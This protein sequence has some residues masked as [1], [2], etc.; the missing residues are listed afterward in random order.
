MKRNSYKYLFKNI[1][2]LTISNFSSKILTF[3]LVLL[4]TRALSTAEFGIFDVMST[5]VALLFPIITIDIHESVL[6]FSLDSTYEKQKQVFSYGAQT[7]FKSI[8]L[9]ISVVI[10]NHY[11]R[12]VS[13]IDEYAAYFILLYVASVLNHLMYNFS[14]G[15]E[16]VKDFAIASLISSVTGLLL[17]IILLVYVKAGLEGYFIAHISSLMIPVL[18]LSMRIKIWKF[19]SINRVDKTLCKEMRGFSIPLIMNQIGWW[20]NNSSD[21]YVVTMLSGI[22]ANGVY[23]LAYKIPSILNVFQL[24]FSQAW[25]LSATKDY[26]SEDKSGFFSNIYNTYNFLMVLIC[27]IIIIGS[28]IIAKIMYGPAFYNAYIYAPFLTIAVVFGALSG[29][30]GGVFS[31]VKDSKIFGQSTIIGALINLVLNFILVFLMGPIGAAIATAIS[32]IVVWMLRLYHV[33]KY[34][35]FRMSLIRDCISYLLLIIMAIVLLSNITGFSYYLI[36]LVLLAVLLIL[37]KG[38]ILVMINRIKI[39]NRNEV[40]E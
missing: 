23:S 19:F 29:V 31:A 6:R 4:Y 32:F 40:N 14:R 3:L 35:S 37:Y 34:I 11:I 16:K 1:G 7:V 20:I 13:I 28:K 12:L 17:N 2:L 26:D 10:V 5:T 15:I 8:M 9:I 38:F 18:Y 33:K 27:S 21:R 36:Q 22:S 30:L 39:Q 25:V 24:I